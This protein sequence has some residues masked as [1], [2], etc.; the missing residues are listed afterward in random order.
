MRLKRTS[1]VFLSER[2]SCCSPV[3]KADKVN[4][5]KSD[6]R[7]SEGIS[8]FLFS[9][10]LRRSN[11]LRSGKKVHSLFTTALSISVVGRPIT[12]NRANNEVRTKIISLLCLLHRFD[13]LG[14]QSMRLLTCYSAMCGSSSSSGEV[15]VAGSQG[16]EAGRGDRVCPCAQPTATT[17]NDVDSLRA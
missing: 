16:A 5:E 9:L 14:K 12:R 3:M 17:A 10:S 6:V 15:T 1:H 4:V 8:A 11:Y 7:L 13:S 2:G